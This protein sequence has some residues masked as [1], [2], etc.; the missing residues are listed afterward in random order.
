MMIWGRPGGSY[1]T[2]A[3][4]MQLSFSAQMRDPSDGLF[5]HGVNVANGHHSCCKWGRAN[6]WGML[7][8]VEVLSA[9]ASFPGHPL[10]AQ[11]LT[12]YRARVAALLKVQH[13]WSGMW[14]QVLNES[15]TYLETSATAMNVLSIAV[16]VERGWLTPASAYLLRGMHVTF[17]S[18]HHCATVLGSIS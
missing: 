1:A 6:G 2:L 17:P 5:S 8:H 4:K 12:G 15:G 11:V 7:S 16:G 3:A 18:S 10:T 13:V 9:L 14:H